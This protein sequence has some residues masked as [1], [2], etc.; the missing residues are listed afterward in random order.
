MG[1][2]P[3]TFGLPTGEEFIEKRTGMYESDLVIK[4]SIY[5]DN[6]LQVKLLIIPKN[7]SDSVLFLSVA[8][9]L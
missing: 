4:S 7:G 6:I 3:T 2:Q 8:E 5:L 1:F 9:Y